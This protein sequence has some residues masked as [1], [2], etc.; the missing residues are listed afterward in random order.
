MFNAPGFYY[1]WWKAPFIEY[2]GYIQASDSQWHVKDIPKVKN[3]TN[4]IAFNQ[5][6]EQFELEVIAGEK[7][8]FMLYQGTPDCDPSFQIEGLQISSNRKYLSVWFPE[9]A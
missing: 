9:I 7:D 2:E 6:V 4:S 1:F 3:H 8:E 5:K